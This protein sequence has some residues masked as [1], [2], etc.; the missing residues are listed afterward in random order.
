M[1][2]H[3]LNRRNRHGILFP[4]LHPGNHCLDPIE[5]PLEIL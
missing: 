5:H 4:F 1:I 2:N 3:I